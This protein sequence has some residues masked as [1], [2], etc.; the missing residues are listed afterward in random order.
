MRSLQALGC[1][2][3]QGFAFAKPLC[4][5]ELLELLRSTPVV[6]A[7]RVFLERR[8]GPLAAAVARG[9]LAVV[10]RRSLPERGS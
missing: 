7:E 9:A 1:D 4:A 6:P 3:V 2:F 10:P 5:A 8:R